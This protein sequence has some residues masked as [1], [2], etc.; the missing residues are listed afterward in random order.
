MLNYIDLFAGCGGLTDGFES[1]G[2]YKG[3]AFVEWE[4]KPC[5]TLI[6]RLKK[7]WDYQNADTSTLCFDIQRTEEL[8]FG[9]EQDPLYGSSDG[10]KGLIGGTNI[11]LVIGG[12]PCQA[13]SMAGRVRD[14]HGMKFDYRNYLFEGYLKIVDHYR[15]KLFVFE[16][17]EGILSARPG[18]IPI[19]IRI[20]KSLK[21]IGFSIIDDIRKYALVNSADYNVPQVRKRVIIVGVNEEYFGAAAE[22]I[23]VDYYTNILPRYKGN[24]K[25]VGPAIM[26]LPPFYPVN[27]D[28]KTNGKRISH[29]SDEKYVSNHVPRFHSKRDQEIFAELA[30]DKKN[31]SQKYRTIESLKELYFLKTGKVSNFH[32]YNVLDED[33]P[34]NTIPAHLYKDGL[35]HIHPD[36]IQARTITPREAARLQGFDDDFE[37]IG[38]LGDQYKMIGNAVPPPLADKIARSVDDLLNKYNTH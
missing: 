23:L 16:N 14:E 27:S 28:L 26:D 30:H 24:E 22:N 38:S 8:I 9:W 10:L 15:P 37:F 7:K 12:P 29:A 31:G 18:D 34:S 25:K 4:N 3:V 21:E 20:K 5:Q 17:V 11:D 36:P 1:T 32:K 6:N 35:R 2:H 33:K 19:T 13:Y